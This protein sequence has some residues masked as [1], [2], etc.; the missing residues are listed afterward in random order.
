MEACGPSCCAL[1]RHK[2]PSATLVDALLPAAECQRLGLASM[3][4]RTGTG[5]SIDFH[6]LAPPAPRPIDQNY[7]VPFH[8]HADAAPWVWFA[9]VKRQWTRSDRAMRKP[10]RERHPSRQIDHIAVVAVR[11][12]HAPQV[13]PDHIAFDWETAT[14]LPAI[15]A[16]QDLRRL[17]RPCVDCGFDSSINRCG[18]AMN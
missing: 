7:R 17:Q 8:P 3:R 6:S 4:I 1:T 10:T 14:K 18:L 15:A 12:D 11:Q 16:V 5:C 9:P 13:R 2:A